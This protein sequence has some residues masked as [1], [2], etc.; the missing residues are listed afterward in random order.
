MATIVTKTIKPSGGDYTSLNAAFS[1]EAK[2][3]VS[4]DQSYVFECYTMTDTVALAGTFS[5]TTDATHTITIRTPLAERHKGKRATG[6][7]LESSSASTLLTIY[8]DN[9]IFDGIAFHNTNA[10]TPSLVYT[11][12]ASVNV[13]T[14]INCLCY[15]TTSG[16]FQCQPA[17]AAYYINCIGLHNSVNFWCISG[18][19]Y[20]YNCTSLNSTSSGIRNDGGVWYLKN[21]FSGGA[22][23]WDFSLVSGTGDVEHLYCDDT[24]P[25]ITHTQ[26]T[27]ASCGFANTTIGT[28]D[29]NISTSSGLKGL[30]VDLHANA[31]YPFNTD[32]CGNVRTNGDANWDI[33]ARSQTDAGLCSITDNNT[34]RDTFDSGWNIW[35]RQP[36][37]RIKSG[38]LIQQQI[39]GV[40]QTI[41]QKFFDAT[42]YRPLLYTD[43]VAETN[44]LTD[45]KDR[46][47]ITNAARTDS[48][49]L[50]DTKDRTIRTSAA[51]T[52]SNTLTHTQASFV[53]VDRIVT[54][55]P[56]KTY[57]TFA[58]AMASEPDFTNND[59]NIVFTVDAGTY[60]RFAFGTFTTSATHKLI[61]R[62]AEGSF[63]NFVRNSGVIIDN[64]TTEWFNQGS[65]D[66]TEWYGIAFTIG[67]G[68]AVTGIIGGL[69]IPNEYNLVWGCLAYDCHGPGYQWNGHT[70]E[71]SGGAEGIV[72]TDWGS[73]TELKIINCAAYN[74]D[75]IGLGEQWGS[76]GGTV[77]LIYN[78]IVLNCGTGFRPFGYGTTYAKNLYGANCTSGVYVEGGGNAAELVFTTCFS[79]DGSKGTTV[80][81]LA[82]CNFTN[83]TV[84]SENINPL[85]ST[86]LR[87]A[88]TDLHADAYYAFST[89][90][91]GISRPNGSNQWDIGFN[92]FLD[93]TISDSVTETNTLID[94]KDKI[95][96]GDV[97]ASQKES[98]TLI[99]TCDFQLTQHA[100]LIDT[101]T[102]VD[103]KNRTIITNAV[104][105]DTNTLVDTKSNIFT[106]LASL[107]DTNTLVDT[108]NRTIITNAVL[109]DTN[110]LVD[111]KSN[112]FT[113][114][115]S[116]T[117]TNTLVDTKNRTIITT[118]SPTD[119]NTLVDTK[120]CIRKV[121]SKVSYVSTAF[122]YDNGTY[123][124]SLDTSSTLNIQIGDILVAVFTH[125][126][127]NVTNLKIAETDGTSNQMT[128][129]SQSNSYGYTTAMGYCIV[130]KANATATF[131]R[132]HTESVNYKRLRVIQFR[133]N[134]GFV[135]I[136]DT[137]SGF[138]NGTSNSIVTPAF[139]AGV[140]AELVVGFVDNVNTG[141]YYTNNTIDRDTVTSSWFNDPVLYYYH[142][143][144]PNDSGVTG[145]VN[146]TASA[147]QWVTG[148]I[149]ISLRND[150]ALADTNKL[151]DTKNRTIITATIIT[152][153]NTLVDN[154]TNIL[155]ATLVDTNILIDT[156]SV[157]FTG[158]ASAS[159]T[160]TLIDTKDSEKYLHSYLDET[161]TLID[162]KSNLL[163]AV[164][165]CT[166]NNLLMDHPSEEY[167]QHARAE[168]QNTL[169]DSQSNIFTGL[170]SLVETDTLIDTKYRTII[171]S[172]ALLKDTNTLTDSCASNIIT[173]GARL[174][175][176]TLLDNPSAIYTGLAS[177]VDTNILIDY[178]SS[179]NVITILVGPTRTYTSLNAALAGEQKDLR[180]YSGS[181]NSYIFKCDA[182]QDT[183]VITLS[184]TWITDST[185]TLTIQASGA[186]RHTGK[187]GT[188]YRLD[189]NNS[190]SRL[191]YITNTSHHITFNGISFRN[192]GTP[193]RGIYVS[194]AN[195][196]GV[197]FVNCLFAD[198]TQPGATT[199]IT[200]DCP[201]YVINSVFL[202]CY[203]PI[204]A[205]A[206]Y[207]AYLYNCTI[208]NS[209]H[210]GIYIGQS[211]NS[212]YA[213]NCY[214][215]GSTTADY[216]IASDVNHPS[217]FT[218]CYSSDGT[219][220][221]PVIS[222]ADCKFVST[223]PGSEDVNIARD[224]KLRAIGTDLHADAT[225]PFDYDY[226]GTVRTGLWDIGSEQL[227]AITLSNAL[228]D[229]NTLVDTKSTLLDAVT[230]IEEYNTLVDNLPWPVVIG[231]VCE[232]YELDNITDHP[233]AIY[234][235]LAS[236]LEAYTLEDHQSNTFI[237]LTDNVET[238]TLIDSTNRTITTHSAIDDTN[239]LID[240][241]DSL[242]IQYAIQEE[243]YLLEDLQS[244]T[245]IGIVSRV[246]TN[247]LVDTKDSEKYLHSYLD[248]ANT[249]IDTKSNLLNAVA[250][251]IDN[252]LLMDHPSEEY[253]Q[254]SR[255]E[256]QNTLTD[257]QSNIFTG[258]ADLTETNT[259]I[260]TKDKT[261]ITAAILTDTNNLNATYDSQRT[262]YAIITEAEL[263]EDSNSGIATLLSSISET[264]NIIDSCDVYHINRVSEISE[265]ANIQ[266]DT[267]AINQGLAS[268]LE[269]INLSDSQ[270]RIKIINATG[271]EYNTI[272][273]LQ[274]SI[275][276]L[277][278]AK[279]ETVSLVD[280]N[281]CTYITDISIT[282][283]N[284]L[285]DTENRSCQLY[286]LLDDTDSLVDDS[287]RVNI[288]NT[289][290][291]DENTLLDQISGIGQLLSERIESNN[292]IDASDFKG[293]VDASIDETNTLTDATDRIRVVSSDI[294]ENTTTNDD[295]SCIGNL[296]SIT[297]ESCNAEDSISKTIITNVICNEVNI[298]H[299]DAIVFE[300]L[301][302]YLIDHN[303]ALDVSSAITIAIHLF[304]GV[305]LVHHN[306]AQ[307]GDLMINTGAITIGIPIV[308]ATNES[309]IRF[310]VDNN[311][312]AL[313]QA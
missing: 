194:G 60:P 158:L 241:E 138:A 55:G 244:N 118:A 83:T 288:T 8:T 21:C 78:C 84:G 53:P 213:K 164:A 299:D 214:V 210:W 300:T 18:T 275:G 94:T 58:T 243:N 59:K 148:A 24:S 182:Y 27:L 152:E 308:P 267:F 1:G 165:S 255:I 179:Y 174:E 126:G 133:P 224:S 283:T 102:L 250:G 309:A 310:K 147:I 125:W 44:T 247:I 120:S 311:V 4:L 88:G 195:S 157:I 185:H 251:C 11:Y 209:T 254:H 99:D 68:S 32:Y 117:N 202:G 307:P 166:D 43:S 48:N 62:C 230:S 143:G 93:A 245:F 132:S 256:E 9:V 306:P 137:F 45:T 297:I 304:N 115:A 41:V 130:N 240:T 268:I 221:I 215:G 211:Y 190:T 3:I 207:R 225:Y 135:G 123:G 173:L 89:D 290:I 100:S 231:S 206:S 105:T 176:V 40:S 142:L 192:S 181:N 298:L 121:T 85:R 154:N 70:P 103:T 17:V 252:N 294:T 263:L 277:L 201:I 259:L 171:T 187:R 34:L 169:V 19:S 72:G 91:Y 134:L 63:H 204:W 235:G 279:A 242:R 46:T 82:S 262:Q 276:S 303:Q 110:T 233:S 228:T 73:N 249:L 223:T 196:T 33:G 274:N 37:T 22:A 10:T 198:L 172:I 186:N 39:F 197:A 75:G 77:H 284:T 97:P 227:N 56:G 312:Y 131:R 87:H 13:I 76:D 291:D 278:A 64:T 66:Y 305:G 26:V 42:Y 136:Y 229:T 292:L 124:T 98:N 270:N 272:S 122:V 302:A 199:G 293:I 168:E 301:V 47:I 260:D 167:E 226:T 265:Q 161:N 177:L 25:S 219:Y 14:F 232:G 80:K 189:V 92:Q 188:G 280:N 28:E 67:S 248:E 295:N 31:N 180:A 153:T 71:Y 205:D 155:P 61:I 6:Y 159:D 222:L 16:A 20:F 69:V 54:I 175:A 145:N 74:C 217:L 257:S 273:D 140:N 258:L 86:S 112:I 269:S 127:S 261:I 146:L 57:T 289:S 35:R 203:S 139:N 234:T 237:G 7:L 160:N 218:T 184:N 104:L 101:N 52:D 282:D 144:I 79:D 29:A 51:C 15:D 239:T 296:V 178:K 149:A 163:N 23:G 193:G 5:W 119:T 200:Y 220:S 141:S 266:D 36:S 162:I 2:N 313:K 108:K 150:A 129:T 216:S 253:E 238:N 170:A 109:T 106:R 95:K 81:T 114:L 111:T 107:T 65:H 113:R 271:E 30:G 49:T 264:N 212:V 12:A 116:L 208:L 50:T 128:L 285:V 191:M 287:T 281:S 90:A 246:D 156:K 96:L 236:K 151:T 38:N 183:T 286:S